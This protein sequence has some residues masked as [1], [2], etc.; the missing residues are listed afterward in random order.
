MELTCL[1]CT[2][3]RRPGQYLCPPCWRGLTAAAR[4][5]LNRNDRRALERMHS[6]H[7][8]L[9]G[10]RRLDQIEIPE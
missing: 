9:R 8:Q 10:G 5:A 3:Q 2:N 7:T 1:N 4:R 6:L